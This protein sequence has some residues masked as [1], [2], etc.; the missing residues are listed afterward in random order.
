MAN[1]LLIMTD[2]TYLFVLVMIRYVGLF[3][4]TPIL[5][6]GAYPKPT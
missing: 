3:I 5:S 1:P 4:V 6:S 2:Y